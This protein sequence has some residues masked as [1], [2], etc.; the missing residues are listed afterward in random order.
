M[1]NTLAHIGLQGPVSRALLRDADLKWVYLGS[2]VPD[3]PW[4]AR[5]VVVAVW[6]RISPYEI[7]PYDLMSYATVRSSLIL[8]WILAG[9]LASVSTRPRR[10]FAILALG[11][12]LHL[13]LDPLQTKWANGVHL[14]APFSW[15]LLNFGLFWPEG[16]PSVA[17]TAAGVGYG[18]WAW[19]HVPAAP[20]ELT[21]PRGRMLALG[22]L[23]AVAYLALPLA[24][25]SG[26]EAADNHSVR[27]LREVAARPGRAVA[28]D[29]ARFEPA[30]GG[31]TL[32]T[33]AG[34]AVRLTGPAVP[35]TAGTV[36]I[37]G[38]F[39]DPHTVFV[40]AAHVHWPWARDMASY[41]GLGLVLLVWLRRPGVGA[42]GGVP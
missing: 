14:F 18:L 23:C 40:E 39:L 36:S 42:G 41:L 10:A 13:L 22:G 16:A 27:T 3:V 24:L 12:L 4:I 29:R 20:R 7:S 6:P 38:R 21:V 26:P 30:P 5:R 1:P 15:E 28:F 32:T 11:A 2:I 31:G 19:R 37:R 33:F 17:L 35:G 8:C 25:M 34:E 9:A